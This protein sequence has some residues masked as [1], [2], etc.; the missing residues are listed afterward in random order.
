MYAVEVSA[1]VETSPPRITLQWP[2]DPNAVGYQVSRKLKAAAAWTPISNLPGTAPEFIDNNVANGQAFEYQILKTTS[3]NYI[4]SGYIYAGI[5]LPPV[6][7]RGKAILLLDSTWSVPLQNEL[8]T[9]QRDLIGDGW[10]LI[11]REVPRTASPSAVRAIIQSIYASDPQNIKSLFLFGHIPV[12][13]SGNAAPDSHENHRGAWPA[14]TYYADLDGAWT[15]TSVN[16]IAAEKEWNHNIPGDGKFDQSEIPSDVELQVGRVDLSYMTCYSNKT[17]PRDEETLLRQYLG[18]D[19]N[20][21]HG[22]LPL[23]RRGLICD[24]F[25]DSEAL[26]STGWR[27]FAA[28]FGSEDNVLVP[29]GSYLSTL[30]NQGYLFTYA[31]GGGAFYTCA[32]IGGA[33][34]FAL[35]DPKAVFTFFFGSYFG[36]WDNESNFLRAPLGSTTYTL[37]TAWGGRPHWFIHH[38]ALGETI[39]YAAR[40]SQN[41]VTNGLYYPQNAG[42]RGIH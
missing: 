9:L 31:D 21:R 3:R 36:D 15:D 2:A 4:G 40:L 25:S 29:W 32:G 33:D 13:Y 7:S 30:D 27:N 18:K 37:T 6:E 38:M 1:S 24:N 12:P 17:P 42:T 16:N 26:A 28:L 8:R 19:H 11:R 14:D 10:T 41:N 34:D 5:N 39:G 35:R 22:L 23:P 20:F